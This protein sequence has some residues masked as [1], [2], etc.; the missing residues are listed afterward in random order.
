MI[1][2]QF[3]LEFFTYIFSPL[4]ATSIAWPYICITGLGNIILIMNAFEKR[5]VRRVQVA[6]KSAK[7]LISETFLTE[8]KDLFV[9]IQSSGG[10]NLYM[11]DLDESNAYE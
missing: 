10:Y 4:R 2:S 6:E 7:V 11:I 3:D 5:V 1:H 8:T 9:I